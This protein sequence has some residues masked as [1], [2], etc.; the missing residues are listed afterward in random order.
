M[1]KAKKKPTRKNTNSIA[2]E[3]HLER[4]ADDAHNRGLQRTK[5][6]KKTTEGS[7]P[8]W[9]IRFPKPKRKAREWEI[10]ID[11]GGTIV[12]HDPSA[13]VFSGYAKWIRVREILPRTPAKKRGKR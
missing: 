3:I 7:P 1:P 2:K 10:A 12:T 8:K 4:L 5:A 9:F 13:A 6:K 11:A